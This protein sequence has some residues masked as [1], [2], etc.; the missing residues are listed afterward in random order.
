MTSSAP[1]ASPARRYL[2]LAALAVAAVLVAVSLMVVLPPFTMLLFP[3][4]VGASEYSPLLVILDLLWCLP[5]NRLLRGSR[6]LRY[7][8]LAALLL[9]ACV[10]VRPLS[11]YT[12][13]ATAASEQ[14]GTAGPPPRFSLVAAVAGL[15]T[16]PDVTERIIPY[17]A[18]D[19]QRL[20][21]RLYA[22]PQHQVRPTVVVLY[23]GAWRTGSAVQAE[24]VSRA[25]A[26]KG[27][28]VAALDYRHAPVSPYPAQ[29]DD[30]TRG[31]LLLQDSADTWG[32]DLHRIAILGRSS[33]G[34]LAELAAFAPSGFRFRAVISIYAPYDL[35]AGYTDLPSPN[36][37]DVQAV[38]RSFMG[39]TPQQRLAQYRLASPSSY[40]RAGLPPTLLLFGGRD[41]V[42]KPEFN[43]KASQALRAAHVPVIS[44]ELPWAEHGFDLA[45]SGLG[46]QLA[47]NLIGDFLER[48]LKPESATH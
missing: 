1:S 11:Q 48:E 22:L 26:A 39:G 12:R 33:G 34:H 14:L 5:V 41:H 15:P 4:A 44:V 31:I 18:P 21:M 20:T 38:L 2:R 42:V 32:I 10:A 8:T 45:P 36:P 7:G 27:Y 9:G 16:S 3:L 23:G 35:V 13:I 40:V 19:G 25:L 6:R 29:S 37:I 46:G 30:V 24:N 17:A 28:A 47:F 43:R